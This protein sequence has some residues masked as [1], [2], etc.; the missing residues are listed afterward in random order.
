VGTASAN[1]LNGTT[2][3]RDLIQGLGGNDTLN[4]LGGNDRL[5][6][7]DG[8]DVLNA[9][10]GDDILVG[11]AG[12]D[13]QIG[14]AGADTFVYGI[15]GQADTITDFQVGTDKIEVSGYTSYVS[16]VQQGSDTLIT[17]AGGETILL[18]NVQASSL[19]SSDF[20]FTSASSKI[21]A[22]D[23]IGSS[24]IDPVHGADE[25]FVIQREPDHMSGKGGHEPVETIRPHVAEHHL[26]FVP[27]A[28]A[29]T[30]L[31][32][33]AGLDGPLQHVPAQALEIDHPKDVIRPD[34]WL[35]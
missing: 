18:K 10:A 2:T 12:N 8:N 25:S 20:V 17:F 14:G 13:T 28:A 30:L 19:S 35:I 31:S 22:P 3:T 32:G 27:G 29:S 34:D 26:D 21:A 33:I 1:T 16:A 4:G 23:K 24:V 9:G 7:G 5:E 15:G 6:G 11:G